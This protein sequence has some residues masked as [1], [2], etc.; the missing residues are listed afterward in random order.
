METVRTRFHVNLSSSEVGDCVWKR[1]VNKWLACACGLFVMRMLFLEALLELSSSLSNRDASSWISCL[2]ILDM[3]SSS[4]TASS[5]V[6]DVGT[7]G[8]LLVLSN[9]LPIETD[10]Y[11]STLEDLE[12]LAAASSLTVLSMRHFKAIVGDISY[13]WRE[14]KTIDQKE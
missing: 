3:E 10:R 12:S 9:S 6:G 1:G 7:S 8:E 14:T 4:N 2:T 11:G 5:S 13:R